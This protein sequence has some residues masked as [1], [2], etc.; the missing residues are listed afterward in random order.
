MI[1]HGPS[2]VAYDYDLGPIML[3][4]WYHTPYLQNVEFIL[5]PNVSP[6]KSN[7]TLINGKMNYDCSLVAPGQTC[8]PNA[9]LSKFKFH[10][11]KKHRLRLINSGAE[12][13][14]RFTIDGHNMTIIANDFVPIQPYTT[15]VVTLG[16]GQRSDVIV[17]GIGKPDSAYWMRSNITQ[18]CSQADQPDALAVIYYESADTTVVPTT[19]AQIFD[20]SSCG[21]V[22]PFSN[23]RKLDFA[24]AFVEG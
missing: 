7:N 21:N 2:Q 18:H 1:I 13:L 16:I 6:I 12:G 24:D 9:G 4:D 22:R 11:G 3:S 5:T 17:E 15:N 20:D 8:V 19:T 14:Q 23:P 10:S